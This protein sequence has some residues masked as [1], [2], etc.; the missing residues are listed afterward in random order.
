MCADLDIS[1]FK[2]E[3]VPFSKE[4]RCSVYQLFPETQEQ[5]IIE[6]DLYVSDTST[7]DHYRIGH[8]KNKS[9]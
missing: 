1:P 2:G 7:E 6:D 3:E 9:T 4:Y 5:F 8:A